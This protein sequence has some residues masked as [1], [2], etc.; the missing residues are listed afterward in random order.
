M[1]VGGLG[2]IL[3]GHTYGLEVIVTCCEATMML[4]GH[5]NMLIGDMDG[6]GCHSNIS[7]GHMEW[8]VCH[9]NKVHMNETGRQ[10]T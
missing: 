5:N 2:N 8:V 1:G 7:G 4:G 3:G 9:C 10:S 6:V